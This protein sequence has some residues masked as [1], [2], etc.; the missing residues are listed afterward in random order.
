MQTMDSGHRPQKSAPKNEAIAIVGMACTFPKAPDLN[1]YWHN[2]INKV[3]AIADAPA[4]RWDASRFCDPQD[5]TKL[6]ARR[7]G[8]L[9]G[10]LAFEAAELGVM[11]SAVVGGDPDQFLVLKTAA[12]AMR[13]A[14][15]QNDPALA[16]TDFILGRGAYLSAGGFNLLQRTLVVDQ[17]VSL[18]GQLHPGMNADGLQRLKEGLLAS[19][20]PF[21]ADTAA[22]VMPNLTAGRVSNRL[23]FMGPNYTIDA[24]CASSLFAVDIAVANLRSGRAD[25]ALAGGVHIFNT[26]PFLSVFCALGAMSR[27]ER[28]RPFDQNADGLLP[29]EGVGLVV[30]KRL[31]DAERDGNRIYALIRGVGS[32]SDGR[33]GSVS[34]PRVAGEALAVQRAYDAAGV[35]PETIGLIE[36]HGTATLVGD[37]TE[38]ESLKTVF[39]AKAGAS[40]RACALGSVKSMIGHAMPAA[41]IAGLIKAVLALH[42]KVLPPTLHCEAP[43]PKF[44]LETTPFYINTAT[45][46]WFRMAPDVPRRAGVNAF[47]FG[48]VNAHVVLEEYSATLPEICHPAWDAALFLF[49]GDSQAALA[50]ACAAA[51][52]QMQSNAALDWLAWSRDNVRAFRPAAHRLAV[53]AE[54]PRRSFPQAGL[55]H[56]KA[57]SRGLQEDQGRQG[58]LLLRRAVGPPGQGGL[59][60]PGRRFTLR[61]HAAGPVPDLSRSAGHLRSRG[62]SDPVPFPK[63]CLA[64]QPVYLPGHAAC[65]HSEMETL[66]A[67]FWKVDS[68]LQAILAA[69]LA[70][71]A[72]LARFGVQPDM[73]VGH[74]AG[75][76]CA[77]IAA[78]IVGIDDLYRHQE[79]IAGIY[80]ANRH[81]QETAMMAVSARFD[82]IQPMVEGLGGATLHLQRQLPPP[83]GGGRRSGGRGPIEG[84][85][86]GPEYSLHRSAFPGGASYRPGRAPGRTFVPDLCAD[87]GACPAG[88]GLFSHDRGALSRPG[89]G[90]RAPDDRLLAPPAQFQKH[91]GGHAP[92]RRPDFH[93]GRTRNQSVRL[94][95]RYLARQAVHD[96]GRQQ[97]PALGHRPVV[98]FAGHAG[99]PACA[100]APGGLRSAALDRGGGPGPGIGRKQAQ[101]PSRH[102]FHGTGAAG[103]DAGRTDPGAPAKAF[104]STTPGGSG[105]PLSRAPGIGG[106]ASRGRPR[107]TSP[108]C[109]VPE[110]AAA[111][112]KAGVMQHY[113]AQHGPVP[114]P[115]KAG[116]DRLDARRARRSP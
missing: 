97:Q 65:T 86:E 90:D 16:R 84:A 54:G 85:I 81:P 51:L 67:Q 21:E 68:G 30:L 41:G 52:A 45:R 19:L 23:G 43:N 99:G 93:R 11:P 3:D 47:G 100:R 58:D 73:I 8:Y 114:G 25:L 82:K 83:G 78:G 79:R 4:D 37:T 77:W 32:S 98:P 95:G 36:A 115:A 103:V 38:V 80:T 60:V 49:A 76:Y 71:Q 18:V 44:E 72:L 57:A 14:G 89:D 5:G 112:P 111:S 109:R 1:T 88:A 91:C 64:A 92:R 17:T 34:A 13:D 39:G 10:P 42:H 40:A 108:Y 46:P 113:I 56:A 66:G 59:H 6:Y 110:P 74:S 104:Q 94:R 75:E 105:V 116:H 26:I 48:G 27:K 12:A 101:D 69:S 20:L 106:L 102:G 29:G 61:Q 7:G 55:C 53:I 96:R 87:G 50:Q 22:S 107:Q 70:M 31:S 28:I 33:G 62:C 2:I 24:A 63:K 35:L 9:D 15:I